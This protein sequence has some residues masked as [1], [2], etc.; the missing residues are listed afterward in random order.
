MTTENTDATVAKRPRVTD[1]TTSDK[2]DRNYLVINA[3]NCRKACTRKSK[4]LQCDLCTVW[5]HAHC[6]GYQVSYTKAQLNY[7]FSSVSNLRIIL[8]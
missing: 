8:L 5:V 2:R 7:I 3:P 1:N 4:V 6:E